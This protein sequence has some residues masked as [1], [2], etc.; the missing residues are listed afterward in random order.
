MSMA[1]SVAL[2]I[3]MNSSLPPAGPRKRN[4]LI[5]IAVATVPM[6]VSP[7]DADD[8]PVVA[9]VS[10][11]L[12]TPPAIGEKVTGAVVDV[13]GPSVVAAGA[14]AAKRAASGPLTDS[15]V[16]TIGV[17]LT[18]V[19]VTVRVADAPEATKP[20]SSGDGP[21]VRTTGGGVIVTVK[22]AV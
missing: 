15:V 13:P 5:T 20:K 17:A 12:R 22:V 21:A 18:L 3:S 14:P 10:V 2:R 7:T 1:A 16:R 11:A 8:P 6:P 4:S 19:S 9:T